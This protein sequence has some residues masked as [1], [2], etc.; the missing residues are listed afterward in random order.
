MDKLIE[1]MLSPTRPFI[2]A[3]DVMKTELMAKGWSE[4][5]SEA[6]AADWL[7]GVFHAGFSGLNPSTTNT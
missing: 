4:E 7:R 5:M 6:V 3:A 1:E 2:N